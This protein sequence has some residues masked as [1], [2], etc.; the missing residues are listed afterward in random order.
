MILSYLIFVRLVRDYCK[1]SG[2]KKM[3]Y[4][5]VIRGNLT[6]NKLEYE[7]VKT[8]VV[9]KLLLLFTLHVYSAT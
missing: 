9:S 8:W 7:R 5:D 6:F 4:N 3:M 2:L 1:L